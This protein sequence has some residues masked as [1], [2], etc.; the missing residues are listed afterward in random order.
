MFKEK[1][2]FESSEIHL[3]DR[4]PSQR[5]WCSGTIAAFQTVDIGSIHV[6]LHKLRRAVKEY[7]FSVKD[8]TLLL[9]ALDG[10]NTPEII[11]SCRFLI[12]HWPWEVTNQ[13]QQQLSI[14]ENKL[15]WL[16]KNLLRFSKNYFGFFLM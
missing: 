14:N 15:V 4:R 3:F 7:L 8:W 2:M 16:A 13:K 11:N 9:C 5:R 1:L 10:Q 6:R 12:S